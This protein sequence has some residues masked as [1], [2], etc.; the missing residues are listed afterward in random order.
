MSYDYIIVGAG[1]AGSVLAARLTEGGQH[2]VL[3]L[4][5]G[6]KDDSLWFK[7]P[8][9]FAKLYYDARCNWMYHSTPQ[10]NLDGRC[11]YA[12]R[13][14]VQGGSGSINAMI[15]VRGLPKDFDDWAA[16]GNPGWSFEE[17]LPF[18][19]RLE[20][21]P[22]GNTAY[23]GGDGPIHITPMRGATHAVTD[24][25]LRGCD[26]LG[27]P[28]C[29]DFNGGHVDG[30]GVYDI[31]TRKGQ[32]CSSSVG[33][34]QPALGRSQLS[35]EYHAQAQ[36]LLFNAQ[37]RAEGVEVV[38]QGVRRSFHARREVILAAGAVDSPKLLQ[39]SGIGD[40]AAL[41][42]LGIAVRHALPSVGANLQD[43]LCAS[44]YYRANQPTLNDA[45]RGWGSR[46]R[47]G[48]Q[49]ALHRTGPLAMS[50]N[51]AG[52]FF[53][54]TPGLA[55]PNLQFYFNPLSY[56]IPKN[57]KARIQPEPYPGFLLC[58][59][60]CR[61]TSRGSIR[62]ASADA[63]DA[64][65]IDPNYLATAHDVDEVLQGSRL[66]RTLMKTPALRAVTVE[67]V[68][69]GAAV[70]DDDDEGLLAYFRQ[71]CGSIY[72]LCGSCAMGPDPATAVV[73]ARLRVHGVPGLRIVDASIFPNVTSGN[74]NAAVMMVAE[75]GASMILEDARRGV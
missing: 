17:V 28:A 31:N 33:Y 40:P 71:N 24:A 3:L 7:L 18:F 47:M 75:K 25:F 57:G 41:A 26:E 38:Q 42:R 4:E 13:G 50:V 11:L 72:H 10:P 67:E 14:K 63:A 53:R 52:G 21:H 46:L 19:R 61:P 54:G 45:F 29:D 22:R 55:T 56:Q 5:A 34:L 68:L 27:L 12:P 6:G 49:Y 62:L 37:G 65:L 51:Q 35:I 9:G 69:P 23:H 73:D 36:R 64:A 8:V 32:R 16:Q 20:T 74:T 70:A 60:P 15:Y 59:N 66:I 2:S 1:S 58:F 44:Y 39:L 43:H 30:A 48:L